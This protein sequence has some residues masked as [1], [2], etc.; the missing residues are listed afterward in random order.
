MSQE[1]RLSII[2]N[3][4]KTHEEMSIQTICH[5]LSISRTIARSDILKLLEQKQVVVNKNH[6]HIL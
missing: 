6:I 2:L 4:L 5:Q 3:Y 1:E